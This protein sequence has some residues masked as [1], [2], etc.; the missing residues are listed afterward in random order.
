M[1]SLCLDETGYGA[2]S[3]RIGIEDMAVVLSSDSLAEDLESIRRHGV[4]D[5]SDELFEV[6]RPNLFRDTLEDASSASC[7]LAQLHIPSGESVVLAAQAVNG[8]ETEFDRALHDAVARNDGLPLS[9]I[10]E[11]WDAAL[12]LPRR[13]RLMREAS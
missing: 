2:S 6:E 10:D 11:A 13:V 4:T 1:E 7:L 12:R 9:P 5:G 3:T 8:R